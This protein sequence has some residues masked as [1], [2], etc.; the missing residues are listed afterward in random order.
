MC[1]IKLYYTGMI[2]SLLTREAHIKPLEFK[3]IYWFVHT[4]K[5]TWV[6]HKVSGLVSCRIINI[7]IEFFKFLFFKLAGALFNFIIE[8]CFV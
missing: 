6:S 5:Y 7:K 4:S 1:M 8:T 3:K 2:T